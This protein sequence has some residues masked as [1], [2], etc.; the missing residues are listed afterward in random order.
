MKKLFGDAELEEARSS[1]SPV[2]ITALRYG[3]I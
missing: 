1:A 3:T 2:K